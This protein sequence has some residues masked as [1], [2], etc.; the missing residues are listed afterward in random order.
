MEMYLLASMPLLPGSTEYQ[1][2]LPAWKLLPAMRV[3]SLQIKLPLEIQLKETWPSESWDGADLAFFIDGDSRTN[4]SRLILTLTYA[5]DSMNPER[6]E[7]VFHAHG[8]SHTLGQDSIVVQFGLVDRKR[9][10]SEIDEMHEQ[11]IR[12]GGGFFNIPITS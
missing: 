1:R 10:R 2:F 7:L 3:H 11:A 5:A 9:Y 4:S 6:F 8:R 12:F